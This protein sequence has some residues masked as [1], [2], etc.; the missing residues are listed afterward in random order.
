MKYFLLYILPRYSLIVNKY[1]TQPYLRFYRYNVFGFQPNW[2]LSIICLII[3]SVQVTLIMVQIQFGVRS[4]VPRFFHPEEL[5]YFLSEPDSEDDNCSICLVS[6]K[7]KGS[8]ENI[9]FSQMKAIRGEQFCNNIVL[10]PCRHKFHI[11]CLANSMKN[12]LNC[13]NCRTILPPLD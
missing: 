3:L 10:T 11:E 6:L 9:E 7:E 4:I 5:K 12:K 2:S 13:P 1:L 8:M